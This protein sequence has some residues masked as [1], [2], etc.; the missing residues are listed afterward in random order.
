MPGLEP[1]LAEKVEQLRQL[2]LDLARQNNRD[3]ASNTLLDAWEILPEPKTEWNESYSIAKYLTQ[4]YL[5]LRQLDE[6]LKWSDILLNCD[7]ERIDSGEREFYAGKVC[8][9][10][11]DTDN[12]KKYFTIANEKSEGRVFRPSPFSTTSKSDKE[13][14]AEYRKLIDVKKDRVGYENSYKQSEKEFSNKNFD[15]ALQLINNCLNFDKGLNDPWLYLRKGQC[16]F[17]LNDFEKSADAM[18]RAYM[19]DGENVFRNEDGK[20]LEFLKTK[21]RI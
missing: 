5:S 21:I 6:A 14:L 2:S 1:H 8:F 13:K 15:R 10:A 19:M 7:N 4:N 11:K 3:K 20:Y 17:E 12:A 18:T 9:E 16:L